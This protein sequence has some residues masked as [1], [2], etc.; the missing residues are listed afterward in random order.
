MKKIEYFEYDIPEI[1]GLS[2]MRTEDIEKYAECAALAYKDYPLFHYLTGEQCEH[3]IIKTI[4]SSSIYAM[5][6][7][8]IGISTD[9]EANAIALFAPPQYTGSKLLPFLLN[10]G[11]KLSYIAPISTFFRLLT[12]ESHAMKLKKQYTNHDCWYLY[13]VTVKPDYQNNG[14]CSKL[15]KPMF[16]Y[17]DR[18]GEDCY[19]ETH[20]ENNIAL[21]QHFGFDLVDIST[22]PKTDVKQYSML[23]KPR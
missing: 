18:I 9:K 15:L 2:R 3:E 8:V 11:I 13:N 20:S 1:N 5:K 6:Q 16:K 17:F 21:Y 4:I 14:A 12:Y 23:R 7:E 10:G 19:L 22:I